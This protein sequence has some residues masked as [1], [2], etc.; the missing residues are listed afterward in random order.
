MTMTF[1]RGSATL[2][3]PWH[4]NRRPVAINRTAGALTLPKALYHQHPKH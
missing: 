3:V 2:T 4:I 1:N